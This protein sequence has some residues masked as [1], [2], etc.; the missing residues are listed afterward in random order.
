M[1]KWTRENIIREILRRE[2]ANLPL[3]L[4]HDLQGI[5]PRLYRAAARIFGGWRNALMAAG[6]A[7]GKVMGPRPMAPPRRSSRPSSRWHGDGR[8]SA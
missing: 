6:V 4:R 1:A 2:A 5:D 3:H 7:P 8:C